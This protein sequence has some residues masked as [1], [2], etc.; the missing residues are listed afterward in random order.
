MRVLRAYQ[1]YAFKF[2]SPSRSSL[3]SGRLP[4]HVNIYNDDPSR[5]GAGVPENMTMIPAKLQEAGLPGSCSPASDTS[6]SSPNSPNIAQK[7]SIA[8]PDAWNLPVP[9]PGRRPT[10]AAEKPVTTK[11]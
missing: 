6:S 11:A 1:K 3:Q 8:G 9:S 2:C 4:V 5:P 7:G 10:K